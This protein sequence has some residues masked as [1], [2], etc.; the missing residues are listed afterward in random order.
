MRTSTHAFKIN[1]D[2]FSQYE[3]TDEQIPITQLLSPLDK[4]HI[5]TVRMIGMNYKKHAN[6]INLPIPKYP[7]LFYKPKTTINGPDDDIVI[8][9]VAQIEEIKLDYE[10]ELVVI[11]GK[12]GKDIKE[13]DALDYVLGYTAGNDVS[14]RT[15]QIQRGGS[16]FSTG[17]MFDTWAPIGP[18]IVSPSVI[19]DPNDLNIYSKINGEIRQNSSTVDMIFNVKH[20]ISFLSQGTTLLPGDLIFTGTP[21]GVGNGFN[22]PKWL[23]NGDVV[24]IGIEEIGT[25]INKVNFD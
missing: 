24:E 9:K 20:L 8:P 16:Q 15:W 21:Q 1:G 23:R 2:I 22:P 25:I 7:C 11:I 13:A 17:K 14:Q 12:P 10:A 19:K 6:E 4:S 3:I 18:T 5:N